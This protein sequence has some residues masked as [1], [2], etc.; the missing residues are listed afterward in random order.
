MQVRA[1]SRQPVRSNFKGLGRPAIG[2][3]VTGQWM[4]VA[5]TQSYGTTGHEVAALGSLAARGRAAVPSARRHH[6]AGRVV[7]RQPR[8][9][10]PGRRGCISPRARVGYAY[11]CVIVFTQPGSRAAV[12]KTRADRPNELSI[13]DH[14]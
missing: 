6:P 7:V 8:C 9:G 11:S 13:P 2:G 5:A 3:L 1:K 14:L 12:L 10:C 4:K